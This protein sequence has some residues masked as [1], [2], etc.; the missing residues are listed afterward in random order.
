MPDTGTSAHD[1][2]ERLIAAVHHA[3]GVPP[4][5]AA[6][7]TPL[8][9][10][11]TALHQ[12]LA[13]RLPTRAVVAGSLD[14]R[15]LLVEN[16]TRSGWTIA[17]LS[18]QEH[19]TRQWPAWTRGRLP[20]TRPDSWLSGT[21]VAAST[22]HRLLKPHLLLVALYHPEYFPL[23]RFP[24]AISDV[25]R[26][27]RATLMGRV[28]LMDMQLG[29][30]LDDIVGRIEAEGPDIVGISATFGQHDL[31]TTLMDHLTGLADPPLVVAGGSL[32]ARNEKLLLARYPNLLIARAAGE[33]TIQDVLAYG[34]GDLGLGE[35]RGIGYR[36][37]VQR[38]EGTMGIG[39]A[40]RTATVSNRLQTDIWPELDL[41]EKTFDAGG[42]AQLE[43]SRGC[44]SSCSFCPRGHKGQWAGAA[45]LDGLPW[46]LRELAD[47]FDRH[48][49][50]SRTLYLVDEEFFGRGDDAADRALGIS[51]ALHTHG[52]RWETSCRIDQVVR[53][54][55]DR[56]WHVDRGH[57][58]RTLV[59]HGLRRCLFGGGDALQPRPGL[60]QGVDL[61]QVLGLGRKA[62]PDGTL[63]R[64]LQPVEHRPSVRAR[65]RQQSPDA[66]SAIGPHPL[67]HAG[68]HL[69]VDPRPDGRGHRIQCGEPRQLQR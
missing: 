21:D 17:D 10:R 59:D 63:G 18:G 11:P 69:G 3:T 68:K 55:E 39:P 16:A 4:V 38:G 23:P 53:P 1:S 37:S 9:H 45:A 41:L 7:V 5:T 58:W 54:G 22:L 32:T 67:D 65:R 24:L 47:V 64:L 6:D 40:R 51:Q 43:C 14:R 26:A 33:P 36:G 57:L 20:L 25:A 30:T 50:V 8:L 31:M 19:R 46:V 66:L 29:V 34:H 49:D 60:A 56:A 42:V 48:P 12:L 35:V 62:C 2:C 28:E 52:F 27:A 15:L 61:I 44:A 13:E